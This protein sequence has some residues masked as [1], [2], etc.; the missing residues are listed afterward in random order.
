MDCA[1][2]VCNGSNVVK[3]IEYLQKSKLDNVK[4]IYL[5]DIPADVDTHQYEL[6]A[7]T[8]LVH[9]GLSDAKEIPYHIPDV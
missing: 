7:W 1:A 3:V 6:Y 5:D 4:I 9:I 2:I 8:R